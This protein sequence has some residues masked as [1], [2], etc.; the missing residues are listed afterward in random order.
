MHVNLLSFQKQEYKRV[1]CTDI[2]LIDFGSATFDHEHHSQVVSTRHYRAPEV[3]LG[4][5]LRRFMSSSQHRI[6]DR[7][8]PE[9]ASSYSVSRESQ[10]CA[11]FLWR[12][13][14]IIILIVNGL[15]FEAL[16]IREFFVNSVSLDIG[17]TQPCDVWSIGCMLF[18][19][20]TGY[21]LFQVLCFTCSVF[22]SPPVVSLDRGKVNW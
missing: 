13:V 22:Y 2:R 7:L 11:Q 14:K 8:I 6:S 17:W 5:L 1:L 4:N 10:L 15:K 12:S 19:L 9:A 18:E 21:T 3:L 20:Y 16:K